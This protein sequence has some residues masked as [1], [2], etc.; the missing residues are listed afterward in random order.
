MFSIFFGFS[1]AGGGGSS[2]FLGITYGPTSFCGPPAS[3]G[4]SCW[5]GLAGGCWVVSCACAGAI[6][7]TRTN[8]SRIKCLRKADGARFRPLKTPQIMGDPR[9][10][11]KSE[12]HTSE[13]Q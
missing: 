3:G 2:F 10:L 6:T 5:F 1:G 12:E 8:A 7:Q 11:L 4:A 9:K 13:L